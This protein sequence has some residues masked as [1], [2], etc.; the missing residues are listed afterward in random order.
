V[1]EQPAGPAARPDSAAERAGRAAAG[2]EVRL[3]EPADG[4]AV[5]ALRA[6]WTFEWRGEAAD[7][8]YP[9]RFAAWWAA[10]AGRRLT[11]LAWT[12]GEP[13]GMVNLAVFERMPAP[14]RPQTRWGYLGNA[15][16]LQA[17]RS[18]GIGTALLTAL[19]DHARAEGFVRIVLSPSE[20][21][22]PFY[23]RAGFASANSLM[24]T[25]LDP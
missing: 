15:F 1:G 10:E 7:D 25:E 6:V 11:W 5:A 19:L 17:W 16:V 24:L 12:G 3:A 21:S 18:R 23:R 20:R 8:S 2:V 13:V 22:L 4:P 9:E 14:G